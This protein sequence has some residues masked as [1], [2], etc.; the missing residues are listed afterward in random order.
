MSGPYDIN[1]KTPQEPDK[2]WAAVRKQLPRAD[3]GEFLFRPR[4]IYSG[5]PEL[6]SG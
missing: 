5:K 2:I 6:L 4:Y 3:Q 1:P